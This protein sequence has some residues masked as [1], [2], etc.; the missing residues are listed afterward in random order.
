MFIENVIYTLY[1]PVGTIFYIFCPIC[2]KNRNK[3]LT[4]TSRLDRNFASQAHYKIQGII[5]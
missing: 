3:V 2:V 1:S 4:N 5:Q